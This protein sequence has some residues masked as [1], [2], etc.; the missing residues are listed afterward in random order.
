ME[1]RYRREALVGFLLIAAVVAFVLLLLWLK[2]Q[3]FRSGHL[4]NVTFP[5]VSG[6]KE[7]DQVM[8]A[9]VLVGNVRT[10]KLDATNLKVDVVMDISHGPAPHTDARFTVRAL[11][12]LGARFVDY[13][14]GTS[15]DLLPAGRTVQGLQE[16]QLADMASSLGGQGRTIM[17][18]AAELVGP[19]T[20]AQLRATLAEAQRALQQI[21]NATNK[22][23]DTLVAALAQ[24]RRVGQRLDLLLEQ[25][26]DPAAATM[27]NFQQASS[28]MAQI[29]QTLTHTSATLDSL[30][31]RINSGRGTI[32]QLANDTTTLSEIRATNR[33]L[34]DLI[35]DFKANPRKYI[36]VR[37]F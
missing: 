21:G 32:G 20:T 4:V 8:V 31:S 37:V 28:N 12:L 19:R 36:N 1:L 35:T 26:S 10:I 2:G 15:P 5:D 25:T 24:L 34:Y 16:P 30:L 11:D 29:S 18:N 22:P 33:A 17:A 6:L 14:P 7:G 9:G 23:S 3:P 13:V 27:R